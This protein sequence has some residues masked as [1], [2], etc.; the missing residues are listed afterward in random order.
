MRVETPAPDVLESVLGMLVPACSVAPPGAVAQ[1]TLKVEERS[2]EVEDRGGL[3]NGRLV[4]ELPYGGRR[5]AV[6]GVDD[7]VLRVTACYR[8]GAAPVVMEVDAR[9]Q[10]TRLVAALGDTVG[11][12]WADYLGRV[13]FAS[14]LLASGWR[15]LHA[16]AVA[17][18]GA[19][20]VFL[21]GR[22]GGKSTLAHRAV[23]ELGA[24]FL[25]DDLVLIGPD[26]TV[27]GWPTRVAVPAE[28]VGDIGGGRRERT[29]VAGVRRDRLLFTPAQHRAALGIAY[30]PP[31]PLGA[32][33]I[34]DGDAAAGE[35]VRA[36]ADVLERAVARAAHVP[37]QL[38]YV[39]D[40]LGLMGGARLADQAAGVPALE[41]LL[42][43]VPSAVLPVAVEQL[44][45][46]PVW[47]AL[48]D[49]VPGAGRGR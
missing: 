25:A 34:V 5:L 21:A 12:R 3:F 28:L 7:G 32:V 31:V 6:V 11:L 48:E 27:V 8:P 44:Q 9:Q 10:V 14:R 2:P 45:S 4:L 43:S 24:R 46:A 18:D 40:P 13:Y 29:V 42:T 20:L 37:Q 22:H 1:W 35:G 38:L 47:R 39:S 19:A 49:V 17:L 26:G 16:S 36:D 23:R 41:G 30:S 33:V 15:M